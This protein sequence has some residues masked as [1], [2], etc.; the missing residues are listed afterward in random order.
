MKPQQTVQTAQIKQ[1]HSLTIKRAG[2]LLLVQDLGR[3]QVQHLG[4]SE[5]GAVDEHAHRWANKLLNN[6]IDAATIE[7]TL[8]QCE[9]VANCDCMVASTGADCLATLNNKPISNWTSHWL[10]KDDTITFNL[11]SS[12]LR[13]YMAVQGGFQ[14]P[15]WHNSRAT[16]INERIGGLSGDKLLTGDTLP[17]KQQQQ[18]LNSDPKHL[19]KVAKQYQLSYHD[20][21]T[22]RFIPAPIFLLLDK[23]QQNRFTSTP[24]AISTDSNRMGYR[25]NGAKISLADACCISKP[26]NFGSIQLPAN[27]QPMVLLKDRQ[28]IG[29]YPVMGVV[30]KRDLFKLSQL[31]PGQEVQFEVCA[32]EQAMHEIK[33]FVDFFNG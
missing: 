4:F 18:H 30:I 21:L 5:C 8:G 14:T 24:Y 16:N 15:R 31:R 26:T 20:K 10:N 7:I 28:T 6:P 3:P 13:T 27:G 9:L 25:F 32:L 22:L 2:P 19:F 23:E 1:P 33:Q 11:G 29:G 12:G 17:I